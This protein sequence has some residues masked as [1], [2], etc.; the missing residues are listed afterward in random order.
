LQRL[1]RGRIGERLLQLG[2]RLRP[3]VCVLDRR[4]RLR[5][6]GLEGGEVGGERAELLQELTRRR[7]G[8]LVCTLLEVVEAGLELLRRR[9]EL[10][11]ELVA[12]VQVRRAGVA[13]LLAQLRAAGR[14]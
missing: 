1:A 13:E 5:D 11:A 12:G 7:V 10:L 3:D 4:H 14:A 9:V 6:L 2:L 8:S